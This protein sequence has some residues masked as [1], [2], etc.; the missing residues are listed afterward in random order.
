MLL[1]F[2][3]ACQTYKME[4]VNLQKNIEAAAK[5]NSKI[6]LQRWENVHAEHMC[7]SIT[8]FSLSNHRRTRKD[9]KCYTGKKEFFCTL[10]NKLE[11]ELQIGI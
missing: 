1:H 3:E 5:K 9:E 10:S 2:L 8:C 11:V 6:K 7:T 4:I